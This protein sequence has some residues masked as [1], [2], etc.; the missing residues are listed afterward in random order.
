MLAALFDSAIC[1]PQASGDYWQQSRRP[2]VSL[3]F[4]LPLLC[5]YEGG[6]LLLGAAGMRNGADVWL[7]QLLELLGFGQYFLLPA[8]TVAVLLAWHHTT[9]QPWRVGPAILYA[10]LAECLALSLV[11]LVI[12]RVQDSVFSMW[13]TQG[14]PWPVKAA[15]WTELAEWFGRLAGYLGAGI[16]E[17][18]LFRLMLLPAVAWGLRW[19]G[20]AD[21]PA[22]IAAIVATS[23]LFSAAHYL[24]PHGDAFG[25]YSFVFRLMAGGFFAVLFVYRGFGIAAGSHA[26]YDIFVGM[27]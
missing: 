3:V 4:L 25:W 23:V 6:V 19:V 20:L 12:A 26:A 22:L 5:I 13:L 7:R 15:L 10:M 11:L 14:Q 1:W 27:F 16:Y 17:E 2:L 21:P 9:R 18:L 24:G 8:L